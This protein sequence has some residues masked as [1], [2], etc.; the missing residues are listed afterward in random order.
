MQSSR[1]K[2]NGLHFIDPLNSRASVVG[3]QIRSGSL[4]PQTHPVRVAE[5]Q[6][7]HRGVVTREKVY[8]K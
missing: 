4:R 1:D 6:K 8:E 7:Q 5:G 3:P 2:E